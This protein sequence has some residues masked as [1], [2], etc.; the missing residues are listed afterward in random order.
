MISKFILYAPNVASGGGLV[1]LRALI[2]ALKG[3]TDV[4][5]MLDQRGREFLKG[6]IYELD[7]RWFHSSIKGRLKAEREISRL[8]EQGD[9]VFCFHNL[10][11]IF[12]SRAR[13]ICY[14]HNA[15]LVGLVPIHLLSGW[16]RLR[17]FVERLIANFRKST[18]E[19]YV[20]QTPTMKS[21]LERW[22]GK[23]APPIDVLPFIGDTGS[24]MEFLK[25]EPRSNIGTGTKWDFIYVSDGSAH[26]NHNRLL[27]AWQILAKEGCFPSLALTLHP[28]RDAHL[29]K[30]ISQVSKEY[31]L[32]IENLG[33]LPHR[34]ILESY[35]ASRALIFPS[36][37]ESF[38]I[39]LI[40]AYTK[41]LPIIAPELDYVRDICIPTETF[42]P[43]S[44]RS[45]ARAVR[46]FLKAFDP[47]LE[48][49]DGDQFLQLLHER[50]EV[51]NAGGV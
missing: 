15:N 29:C 22:Y 27:D 43:Q 40:E 47:P 51:R 6:D 49:V 21:A 38:G 18:I 33:H 8:A 39:P 19:R 36:L 23:G 50:I 2:R 17:Y 13:L 7:C 31:N 30:E 5:L 26:K 46:R 3:R 9:I 16:V 32:R 11:L 14:V 24:D 28:Q 41:G 44:A 34:Q 10:P 4:I 48:L 1:L 35:S 20:V 12:N 37:A 25:N 45:I 42:D